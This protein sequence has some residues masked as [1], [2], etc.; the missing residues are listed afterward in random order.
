LTTDRVEDGAHVWGTQPDFV[1]P[2]HALREELLLQHL[3]AAHP[4]RAVLNVGAGQGTFTN[5]LADRGFEVTSTDVSP[6][7]VDVLRRRVGGAVE[8][9]DATDL[10]FPDASVDAEVLEHAE[11]DGAALRE[12]ARVLRPNGVLALSVP[13]N[14]ALF[15]ASDRWAGHVRRYT[16]ERLLDAVEGAGLRVVRCTPWGFPVSALYHRTAYSWMLSRS[17]DS[18]SADTGKRK[19]AVRLLSLLLR[20][21]RRFVGVE[22]RR[23]RLHPRREARG[24]SDDPSRR[25]RICLVYDLFHPYT[26]GGAERWYRNLSVRLAEAG[27]EVTYLTLRHW[28]AG[29][30]PEIPGVRVLAVGSAMRVYVRGRRR[31]LPPLV[32]GLGVLRHLLRHSRR[33]DVVHTASFPYFSLL[34]AGLVRP[35][36]RFR[37]VVDWHEVW[38]RD[39]WLEYLG[40]LGGRIGWWVQRLC[41]RIPQRAFCFSRLYERRLRELG[42]NGEVAVLEGQFEGAPSEAPLP[43]EPVVVFAGRHIPEKNPVAVVHAVAR[44]RETIPE[45]RAQIYGDGPERPKVLAA[46]AEHGLEGVAEAPGFVDGEVVDDALGRALCL[47]L[48]SSREGYGLVVLEALSRGTPVVLVRGEDNAAVEFVAEGENGFVAPGASAGDLASAIVRVYGAGSE[49]RESTL[50]WF[51]R[52]ETR[53]SL[54]HSLEIVSAAYR[55]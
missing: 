3:L 41:L 34:G 38:T 6:A 45:L 2:R 12:A 26:V 33:Y 24:V 21:D 53:L 49:L 32:F 36:A 52:N 29:D 9:A 48:P 16:K 28:D 10:P 5:L 30:E 35:L 7:A 13:R 47:V 8:A 4:G 18:L 46:I 27:H 50:A 39:Y 14:P 15:S 20:I 22:T 54:A 25:L 43:A 37:L 40:P 11:D 44:A 31:I 51:R 1:G 23:A 17:G 42:V 55:E 19:V